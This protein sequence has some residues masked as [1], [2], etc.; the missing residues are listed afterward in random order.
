MGAAEWPVHLPWRRVTGIWSAIAV[1]AHVPGGLAIHS[2]GWRVWTP[3]ES[4]IPGV[5]GRP[6]DTF[7]LGY[8]VGLVGVAL[9]VPLVVKSRD[10]SLRRLGPTRWHG[11]HRRL[12]WAAYWVVAVHVVALQYAESRDVRHIALTASVFAVALVGRAFVRP[13]VQ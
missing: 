6:L 2:T 9:L 13:A 12:T 4:A 10:A 8:W 3:F 11:L 7:T 1:A 5:S